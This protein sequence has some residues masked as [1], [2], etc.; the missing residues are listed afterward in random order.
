MC[1]SLGEIGILIPTRGEYKAGPFLDRRGKKAGVLGALFGVPSWT[2][3]VPPSG[4][5]VFVRQARHHPGR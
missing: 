5:E 1:P 3:G 4:G 2:G